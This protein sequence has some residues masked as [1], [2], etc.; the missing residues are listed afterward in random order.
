M[1]IWDYTWEAF[2]VDTED[3]Y[4]L[5]TFHITGTSSGKFSPDKGAV[6]I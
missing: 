2:E 5:T 4:V 3:G 1:D 6:L